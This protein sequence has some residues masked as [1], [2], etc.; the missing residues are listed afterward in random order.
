MATK[1][2]GQKTVKFANPPSIAAWASVVGKKEGEGPLGG[3]FD[4]V[5]EDNY[6]GQKT[7][8][9]AE[10]HM[11]LMAVHKAMEKAQ[12]GPK[13]IEYILAGDLLNQS[14]GSTYAL[15]D[16]GIPLIGMYGACSTM[17]ETLAMGSMV[18]DGGYAAYCAAVTSSH[19]CSAERQFR[20]PLDYGGQRPQSSQWTVTGSGAVIL[21]E[22]GIGPFVTHVTI[23]AIQDLGINDANNMGAAMAPAAADTIKTFLE[24]TGMPPEKLGLVLTG[25]LGKLGSD[26]LLKLLGM[27]GINLQNIH[28]DCGIMIFDGDGQDTHSGGS[29]CGC[30]ASV[31]TGRILPDITSG[32]LESVVFVATGA[33]MSPTSVQQGETIPGI[34]HLVRISR[35]KGDV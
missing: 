26:M 29:G 25:D 33:L 24:D 35:N 16:L 11:Q 23:G 22:Q 28:N 20:L 21:S 2:I 27:D 32:R 7:W 31:L 30:Y 15:R 17:A 1:R 14:I 18:I 19:F 4:Y 12:L 34:A 3:C 8:E 5:S 10:S 6:F 13:Q 9:K